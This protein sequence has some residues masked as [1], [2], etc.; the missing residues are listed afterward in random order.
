MSGGDLDQSRKKTKPARRQKSQNFTGTAEF[1]IG[2]PTPE[3][4]SLMAKLL[5]TAPAEITQSELA[6][7]NSK[8]REQTLSQNKNNPG[9]N[10]TP[11]SI[12]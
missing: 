1:A 10:Q 2:P 9:V 4:Q 7:V 6:E 8:K 11:G 5:N 3:W 12:N